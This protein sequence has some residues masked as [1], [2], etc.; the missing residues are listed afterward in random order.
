MDNRGRQSVTQWT[1]RSA[2]L[3]WQLLSFIGN[4]GAVIFRNTIHTRFTTSTQQI[5]K[6]RTTVVALRALK[7]TFSFCKKGSYIS[8]I[9]QFL[10]HFTDILV[11][12]ILVSPVISASWTRRLFFPNRAL[13]PWRYCTLPWVPPSASTSLWL[14]QVCDMRVIVHSLSLSHTHTNRSRNTRTH[15]ISLSARDSTGNPHSH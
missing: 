5:S 3:S 4:S 8:K 13:P 15:T 10:N 12:D 6:N 9:G 1:S 11:Y 2:R 14:C 7:V